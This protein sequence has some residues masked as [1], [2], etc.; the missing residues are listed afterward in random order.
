MVAAR[1]VKVALG[2]LKKTLPNFSHAE[3]ETT[4]QRTLDDIIRESYQ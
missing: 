2:P 3:V 4:N 1:Q